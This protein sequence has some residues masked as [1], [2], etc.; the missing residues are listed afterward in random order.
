MRRV[1]FQQTQ[2]KQVA[3]NSEIENIGDEDDVLIRMQHDNGTVVTFVSAPSAVF[4]KTDTIDPMTFWLAPDNVF[5]AINEDLLD[6]MIEES[7][8]KNSGIYGDEEAAFLPIVHILNV[9]LKEVN[10]QIAQWGEK[11]ES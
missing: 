9:G 11:N 8:E 7:I 10:R 6:E 2:R 1:A 4:E 5:V 3:M